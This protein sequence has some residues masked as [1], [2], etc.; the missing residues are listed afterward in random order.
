MPD[1]VK[2]RRFREL[3]EVQNEIAL[4]RNQPLVGS[5]QRVLCDG[6]SKNPAL[7]SGRNEGNKI[8]FFPGSEEDTG[9][10]INVRIERAEAFALYGEKEG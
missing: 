8:V 5:V 9:R 3:L 7:F 4:S 6:V 1:E 2:G 10:F